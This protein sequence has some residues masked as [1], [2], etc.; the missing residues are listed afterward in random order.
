MSKFIKWAL[1]GILAVG[2]LIK[3]SLWLSVRS[4]MNDAIAQFSP[5]AQLSYRG[6]TSSFDGRVGVEGI[7]IRVPMLNDTFHIAHAEL[8]FKG[9]GELLAFKERLAEGKLPEQLAVRIEGLAIDV[10][11][12][13]M[14]MVHEAPPAP[15][16]E[17]ALTSVACGDVNRIGVDDLLEMGYRTLETD[18][19]FSYRFQP[20]AQNLAFNLTADTRDMGEYRVSL[21][22]ANVSEKPGDM[23][24]NPPRIS[25]LVLEINDNQYQRKVNSY[26]AGKLGQSSEEYLR[27]SLEKLDSELRAQRIALEPAL[28]ESLGGYYRD[29]QALR[30]ELTPTDGAI[31]DG[32]QFF[33][34]KDVLAMLRPVLLINQ[35]VVEPLSFAWVNPQAA[36]ISE[37]NEL[38]RVEANEQQASP[39]FEFVSVESLPSHAGKRLQF[40]TYD[41]TYYQ[42]VLHKVENGRV[43]LSV[44]MGSGSAEMFLRQEKI[45]KVRVLF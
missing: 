34:P 8:K 36:P 23:R 18:A 14:T 19:E 16:L 30:L 6:I 28:L 1:L 27:T 45:D 20:G 9:L 26:C 13:F 40:I 7:E 38:I 4:I 11:G 32:L 21:Q 24:V 25:S 10:H 41:G 12:P 2:I 43:F 3:V 37:P 39:Q 44:Q 33:E 29:P 35:Q 42:G 17:A 31:W 5:F 22:M 15:D